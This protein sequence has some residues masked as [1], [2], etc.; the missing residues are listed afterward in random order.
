MTSVTLANGSTPPT[1]YRYAGTT[2]DELVHQSFPTGSIDYVYGRTGQAGLPLIQSITKDAQTVYLDYDAGGTPQVFTTDTGVENFYVFDGS[3]G[4]I[5]G[6][7]NAAGTVTATY[8]YDPYGDYSTTSSTGSA[9]GLNPYRTASGIY[10]RTTNWIKFGQRW[11]N[12]NTGR[13]TQQDSIERLTNPAQG[14]RYAY[15]ADNPINTI[16]PTGKFSLGCALGAIGSAINPINQITNP[17]NVGDPA[18]QAIQGGIEI[19]AQG[20]YITSL[21]AATGVA[22]AA[23]VGVGLPFVAIGVFAI[24]VGVSD[25][26]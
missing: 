25:A 10:D 14:N 4:N 5:L 2:Q 19:A 18:G 12:P 9:A 23:A 22:T 15:A 1:T 24:G 26:C 13:F 16:D 11:Y 17:L 21:A 20:V 3:I 6:L 8:S 7:I